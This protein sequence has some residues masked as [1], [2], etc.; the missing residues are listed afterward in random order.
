[1]AA[2]EIHLSAQQLVHRHG[3]DAWACAVARAE[4]SAAD[5]DWERV[6]M[7]RRIGGVVRDLERGITAGVPGAYAGA[8]ATHLD[9]GLENRAFG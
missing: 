3:R 6:G 8:S 7:W 4:E 9:K 5:G 1:M 2:I